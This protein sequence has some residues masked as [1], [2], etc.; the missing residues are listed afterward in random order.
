M[1]LSIIVQLSEKLL[2][3]SHYLMSD[4]VNFAISSTNYRQILSE[5]R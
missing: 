3:S 5:N 4:Y 1:V 2:F